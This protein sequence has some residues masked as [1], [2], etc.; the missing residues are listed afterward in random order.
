MHQEMPGFEAS[1]LNF[2]DSFARIGSD[3]TTKF[4]SQS[5]GWMTSESSV[6]PLALNP[7][8]KVIP[9]PLNSFCTVSQNPRDCLL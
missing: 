7:Q 4:I 1:S 9:F 3:G 8:K 6:F 2:D 5:D